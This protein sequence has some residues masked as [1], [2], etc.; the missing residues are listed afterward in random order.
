MDQ[1]DDS[2]CAVF[3]CHL[4]HIIELAS[5]V[6]GW[7]EF[8]VVSRL[9]LEKVVPRLL[10][11]LQSDGRVLKPSLVHGD[12]WDGNT[13]MDGTTWEAFI[14]DV[15]SFYGHN[16][17]DTGN[18]RAPRHRLSD[19][20]YIECYKAR[21]EPSEPGMQLTASTCLRIAVVLSVF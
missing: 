6:L 17:Y 10:L 5:P 3:S 20:A 2:W 13:A 18:W 21:F 16:E 14:F 1:W 15:C 19:K 8:D 7:T 11:P 12:C 9:V 4:G